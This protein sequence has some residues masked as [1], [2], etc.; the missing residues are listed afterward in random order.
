[1]TTRTD[2]IFDKGE[3]DMGYHHPPHIQFGLY[4][5]P[6]KLKFK[7]GDSVEILMDLETAPKAIIAD[8]YLIMIDLESKIWSGLDCSLGFKPSALNFS[9]PANLS[10]RN[11]LLWSFTLPSDIPPINIPSI[12]TFYA[13]ATQPGTGE[14]ISNL[15]TLNIQVY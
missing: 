12:Y 6:N 5:S 14:L 13:G 10:L 3:I 2:G 4:K 1:M 15:A 7:A 9:F 11:T 8:I